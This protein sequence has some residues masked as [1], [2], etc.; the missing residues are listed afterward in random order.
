[1]SNPFVIITTMFLSIVAADH[2]AADGE[3]TRKAMDHFQQ[4]LAQF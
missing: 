2:I 3:N 1:M 4:R